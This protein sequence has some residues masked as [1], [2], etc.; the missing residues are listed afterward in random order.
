MC[1]LADIPLNRK[2][3]NSIKIQLMEK[4][5]KKNIYRILLICLTILLAAKWSHTLYKFTQLDRISYNRQQHK[6]QKEANNNRTIH[7]CR[8]ETKWNGNMRAEKK[9]AQLFLFLVVG[10]RCV[11]AL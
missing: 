8:P 5:I 9:N 7:S 4:T 11:S 1:I 10:V 6:R 3:I 2:C